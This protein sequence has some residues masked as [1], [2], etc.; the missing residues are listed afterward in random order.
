MSRLGHCARS[1]LGVVVVCIASG[2]TQTSIAADGDY[3]LGTQGEVIDDRVMYSV[4]GG[5]AAGAPSSLYRPN[6][7][8]VGVSWRANMMCGNMNLSNTLQNQLNGAT[9]GFQQIMGNVVQSATQAVMSLPALIIQRA[10]PGLYE[11]LSNG[12]MQ[13]RIDFD[14]SKLTCQAMAEKMADK[15]DQAG[16]GALAKN[17]E[18][19][20]NLE[21][22]GGDA[23]T[24]VRNTETRNGN[25]GVTWVGGQRAGGDSQVPVRVTADVVKAGYNLLHNRSV[26]DTSSLGSNCQGGAICQTWE[27]AN[28]AAEWATRV[29]GETEVAT[30]DGCESL[31]SSAGTGLSPLI[32]QAYEEHLLGLQQLLSGAESLTAENLAK[33]SSPMLP[34]SRGVI[35]GLRDDPDQDVL[36]RRLASETALSSII[37]KAL[38]L[39]RTLAA[40]SREPNVASAEPAQLALQRNVSALDREVQLLQTELQVRQSLAT[41]TASLVLDRHTGGAGASRTVEQRDPEPSRLDQV[42]Q[43]SQ[44][45]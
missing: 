14:R 34:V 38:L 5:S 30:C 17:Q 10:N 28:D 11:L 25:N 22:T 12:V 26:D 23:I 8:G 16:W 41:N 21:Q 36:A 43:R 35:E 42:G 19:Q 3:R 6:G 18:M 15:V 40:G 45:P 9:E 39:Q 7:L 27:S 20:E 24:A 4:G 33:V 31:R 29:L 13:G 44:T 2:L 37:Y 1:I 32:Q